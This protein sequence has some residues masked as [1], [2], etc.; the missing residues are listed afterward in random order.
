VGKLHA[1]D[2]GVGWSGS[3][4]ELIEQRL[5]SLLVADGKPATPK[6]ATDET[7]SRRMLFV[8]VAQG[9]VDHL[10]ANPDAFVVTDHDGYRDSVAIEKR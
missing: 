6:D 1:G 2:L 4:A 9:V 10:A 3:L 5:D 7:R 8:A